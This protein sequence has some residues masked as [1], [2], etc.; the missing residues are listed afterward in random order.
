M[1][2][3]DNLI[4]KPICDWGKRKICD[5]LY[6]K[7]YNFVVNQVHKVL[8]VVEKCT[9]EKTKKEIKKILEKI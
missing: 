4:L 2:R 1:S 9:D 6:I 8:E 3:R 7:R 5:S